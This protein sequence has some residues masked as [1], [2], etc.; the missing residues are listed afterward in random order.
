MPFLSV[1][2]LVENRLTIF[3]LRSGVALLSWGM[4]CES[5]EVTTIVGTKGRMTI[6]SPGHC[7]TRLTV[8]VKA[9]GR[10]EK[11]FVKEYEFALPEDTPEIV[12]A[13]GYFYPNSAGFS[14]EAAAVARCIAAGKKEVPQYTLAETLTTLRLMEE[15]QNQL[16]VKQVGS[17]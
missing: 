17:D 6:Q 13:G 7:P 9:H 3:H 1:F 16:G 12:E 14:Y 10:G 11:G 4:A 8:E 5:A 2:S 15:I